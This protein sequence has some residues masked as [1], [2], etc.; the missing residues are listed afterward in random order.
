M[1]ASLRDKQEAIWLAW[2]RLREDLGADADEWESPPGVEVRSDG[3]VVCFPEPALFKLGD[4]PQP[5]RFRVFHDRTVEPVG[6][7]GHMLDEFG[8]R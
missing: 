6:E 4:A 1:E 8:S 3:W 5:R 2:L 7:H